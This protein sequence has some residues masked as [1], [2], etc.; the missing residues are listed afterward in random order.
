[1]TRLAPFSTSPYS[2]PSTS[3]EGFL[4]VVVLRAVAEAARAAGFLLPE[5]PAA[6]AFHALSITFHARLTKRYR[7][8]TTEKFIL[9]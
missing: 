9:V 1:M 4:R 6:V 8:H 2:L 5:G 3:A 7:H